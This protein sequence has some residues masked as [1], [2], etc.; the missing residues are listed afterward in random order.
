MQRFAVDAA[1]AERVART[2]QALFVQAMPEDHAGAA[3]E[4]EWAAHLHEIGSLISHSE[5]HRH[6]AYILDNTD[7][8]GFTVPELHRLG[9]LVLGQRGKVRKIEAE[10]HN[11]PNLARQ[12]LCLRLAV[13]LCHARREPDMLGLTLQ[14]HSASHHLSTRPGWTTAYPQSAY[15]L[16]EEALAWQ[17]TPWELLLELQ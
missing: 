6:G 16:R 12:L 2:A 9:L 5:A 17:K 3:R 15:L 10:L 4:L 13:A 7:V 1:Q 14:A 11:D 8:P